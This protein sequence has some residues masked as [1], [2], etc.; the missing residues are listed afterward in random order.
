M[1]I[2]NGYAQWVEWITNRTSLRPH[3]LNAFVLGSAAVQHLLTGAKQIR[4]RS[5]LHKRYEKLGDYKN[6]LRDFY[7]V[8]PRDVQEFKRGERV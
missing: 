3:F 1:A 6:A 8:S 4:S 5:P 2:L 7:S